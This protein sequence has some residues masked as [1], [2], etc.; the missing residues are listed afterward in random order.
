MEGVRRHLF[1]QLSDDQVA[2]LGTIS[3]TL[4]R[5]LEAGRESAARQARETA[6]E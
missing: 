4:A 5:H 2:E 1:D 3:A 6:Q